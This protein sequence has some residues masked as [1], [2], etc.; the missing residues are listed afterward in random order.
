MVRGHST[1]R[2]PA[3][4]SPTAGERVEVL[5][6]KTGRFS[7]RV[8]WVQIDLDVDDHDHLISPRRPPPGRH[9]QTVTALL[10]TYGHGVHRRGGRLPPA[11]TVQEASGRVRLCRRG[12]A[13]GDGPTL[14]DAADDLV[15]SLLTY[16]CS[17]PVS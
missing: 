11:L 17:R 6:T 12:L 9:G 5:G 8:R 10:P 3:R 2:L 16:A 1:P 4:A 14:Q 13:H 15:Q 7:R